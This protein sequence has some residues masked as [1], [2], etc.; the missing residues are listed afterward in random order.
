MFGKNLISFGWWWLARFAQIWG[1]DNIFWRIENK[2][3]ASYGDSDP[4]KSEGSE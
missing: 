1:L 3:K 2:G 4:S